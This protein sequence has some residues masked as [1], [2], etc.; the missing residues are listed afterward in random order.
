MIAVVILV[1]Y[2]AYVCIIVS[3]AKH[4]ERKW[5]GMKFAIVGSL[6]FSLTYG[7]LR[8]LM[9]CSVICS[10]FISVTIYVLTPKIILAILKKTNSKE[11]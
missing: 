11:E 1:L 7:C 9:G 2:L 6:F 8:H 4:P 5:Q 3:Y 10:F